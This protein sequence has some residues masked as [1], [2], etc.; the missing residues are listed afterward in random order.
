MLTYEVSDKRELL[1]LQ[2]IVSIPWV[3]I[4]HWL[5]LFPIF[6]FVAPKKILDMLKKLGQQSRKCVEFREEYVK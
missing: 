4:S 1:L 5:F 3:L 6:L 2:Y